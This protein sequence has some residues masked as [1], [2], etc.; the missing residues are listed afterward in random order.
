M[1]ADM[2][3]CIRQAMKA[4]DSFPVTQDMTDD[5]S[6]LIVGQRDS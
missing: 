2:T 1:T 6:F 3:A 4:D 5:D